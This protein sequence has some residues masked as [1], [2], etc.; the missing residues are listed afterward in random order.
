VWGILRTLIPPLLAAAVAL[1]VVGT[2]TLV[3]NTLGNYADG[4]VALLTALGVLLL[5]LWVTS[6]SSLALA[7][8]SLFLAC[9]ALTKAEGSLFAS[10]ALAAALVALSGSGRSRRALAL[11]SIVILLPAFAWYGIAGARD[12]RNR[13]FDLGALADPGYIVQHADRI[14]EAARAMLDALIHS[15]SL[16]LAATFLALVLGVLC[17]HVRASVFLA[18]WTTLSFIGLVGLYLI[19]TEDLDWHLATSADRVVFSL[20]LGGF[21]AA[22]LVAGN[23]WSRGTPAS[24]SSSKDP[25]TD[26]APP[27]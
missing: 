5:T 19:S 27:P 17:N 10:A 9:A 22:P 21:V 16:S 8:A 12:V 7:L 15:W 14:P 18:T 13:S 1:A 20:A 24:A 4:V 26:S 23:A 3:S 6:S 25:G 11:A 2:P